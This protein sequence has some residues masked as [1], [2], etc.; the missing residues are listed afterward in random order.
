MT[1]HEITDLTIIGGGPTGLFAQFYA[2]MR[3]ATS[4]IVDA[5]P[6]LGGQLTALY[7]EKYIFDVGGFPKILAKDLVNQLAAQAGQFGSKAYLNERVTGLEQV[8]GHF[9][10]ETDHSEFPSRA[11]LIAGGIG[12]FS[13]RRL[14]QPCAEPWYG[15]GV[16]AVVTDPEAFRDRKIVIIG[17]GDSAFD[18]AHQL[19]DRAAAVTLVHRSDRFRA[20]AATVAEVQNAAAAGRAQL[21]TFHELADITGAGDRLTGVVLKDIKAKSTRAVEADAILPMLGFVSDLG[22]L[23]EWGLQIVNDEIV[24]TSTMETGRPGIYAAGD[25]TT[26]PGKLK[27]IATGFGE[28]AIAVNQ[29]V[30]WIYPDK[31][32]NPGHSSNLDIFGQT[33]D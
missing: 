9:V 24:V 5:L 14:P 26:Y 17:G 30:H 32:V 31:K 29:A 23:T 13:P 27:L 19:L 7:P 21:L 3:R 6:E 33:D 18:W 10:L 1:T 28:A 8:D 15:R 22:A 4:R 12:A 25:I 16:H 20:H 11:V 2:G